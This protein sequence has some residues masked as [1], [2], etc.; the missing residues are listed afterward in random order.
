M[1][2]GTLINANDYV[3]IPYKFAGWTHDGADCIGLV[4][5]IFHEQH[6]KPAI[7][8]GEFSRDWWKT[9]P[10]RMLRFFV[11]N[12][13]IIKEEHDLQC[14]DV[15]YFDINGEGHV[16]IYLDYGKLLTTFPANCKQ[17]DGS[18]LPDESMIVPRRIWEKGFKCGFR[19]RITQ[20]D[21]D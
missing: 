3:G 5:L 10:Y 17:W 7:Y 8:D 1:E 16:G 13:D 11:K 14:G 4:R 15:M 19:R 20:E 21:N 9:E 12:F 18:V 2:K 6:W